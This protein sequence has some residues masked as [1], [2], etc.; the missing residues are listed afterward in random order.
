MAPPRL[1]LLLDAGWDGRRLTLRVAADAASLP[2]RRLA[3]DLDG[4]Y[5]C[6]LPVDA[7][8]VASVVFAFAPA[9]RSRLAVLPRQRRDGAALLPAPLPLDL[10][11]AGDGALL[12]APGTDAMAPQV[13]IVVPVYDAPDEVARCLASVLRHTTG[14]ARLIVIDDASPDPRI[15]PLLDRYA[16]LPGVEVLRNAANRGFTATANR[17][18]EAAGTADVVLLNADTEVGPHWLTGLRRAVA[19]S[20]D[21]ASATAV[22]DNAGAFSVPELECENALPAAWSFD[23][24]ARALWQHAGLA[25]PMLPTGNGFCLYLRRAALDAVGMFDAEAFAQGYG[26]E[27]DW[28]QRAAAAGW[29][30]AIAGTVLVRHARSRSFG[31]ARRIALGVAGMAVLRARWPRY[32]ADVGAS[33]YSYERRVLDWRIRRLYAAATAANAPRPRRLRL[34]GSA[35]GDATVE[36]WSLASDAGGA[37]LRRVGED[38]ALGTIAAAGGPLER[39]LWDWLQRHAI[40][41]IAAGTADAALTQIARD[42][43][44]RLGIGWS[45]PGRIAD[46]PRSFGDPPHD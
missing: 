36:T 28:C 16:G 9:G 3:L 42:A 7:R 46:N 11:D 40:E 44:A 14:R 38:G 27:N 24:T 25:Y 8:G 6:D 30:H 1:P 19:S 13:A 29:R 31:H 43:A 33:L 21:I 32:E 23:D 17:G 45:E 2:E 39:P 35:D 22:S 41:S 10:A 26:E 4:T 37:Q 20:R 5:F 34:D 18:I 12:P 15:A